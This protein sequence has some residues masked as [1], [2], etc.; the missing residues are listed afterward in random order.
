M[1]QKWYNFSINMRHT[2]LAYLWDFGEL[3]IYHPSN[4]YQ[5]SLAFLFF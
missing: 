4:N 1:A 2:Y 5:L 3:I